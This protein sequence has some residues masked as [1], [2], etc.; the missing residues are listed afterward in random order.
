M[1]SEILVGLGGFGELSIYKFVFT[2]QCLDVFHKLLYFSSFSLCKL[3]SLL[4]SSFHPYV[5]IP[6]CLDLLFSL[7]HSPIDPVFLPD[8]CTHLMLHV[9]VLPHL[10]VH[11]RP[12]LGHLL[13][14]R[15]QLPLQLVLRR[16]Q[17]LYR[18]TQ[19]RNLLVLQQHLP[20]V[21]LQVTVQHGCRVLLRD[22]L[23]V[24]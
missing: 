9:R 18:S 19:I 23:L 24:C 12:H 20:L 5:F 16:V 2:S 21:G 3:P 10:A 14:L 8:N 17:L 15:V 6:E 7:A 1:F 13:G 22:L 11:L 4:H